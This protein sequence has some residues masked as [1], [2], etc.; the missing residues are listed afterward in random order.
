MIQNT[1]KIIG[2][3]LWNFDNPLAQ[4]TINGIEYRI[5]DENKTVNRGTKEAYKL[6]SLYQGKKFIGDYT[7]VSIAKGIAEKM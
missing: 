3:P 1:D 4:K 6:Y 2:V 7:S 5:T